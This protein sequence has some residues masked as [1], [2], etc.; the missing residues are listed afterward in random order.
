MTKE[1]RKRVARLSFGT[2]VAVR[3][4][5]KEWVEVAQ[6]EGYEPI[7]GWSN[8][9]AEVDHSALLSRLLSGLAPFD[10]RPPTSHS[11]P[12]YEAA[13]RMRDA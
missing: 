7:T 4:A 12:D 11:Y 5:F 3:A 8:F 10:E 2:R 13:A 9:L 6:R 1:Q